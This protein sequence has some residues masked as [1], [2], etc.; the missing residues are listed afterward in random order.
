M[1][2]ACTSETVGSYEATFHFPMT[3]WRRLIRVYVHMMPVAL[4]LLQQAIQARP[5]K[6]NTAMG[7]YS[8]SNAYLNSA[9]I[10]QLHL[11]AMNSLLAAGQ[12][13]HLFMSQL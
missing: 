6:I 2:G 12:T 5:M 10:G 9:V 8:R 7:Y 1:D 4:P 3:D 11:L 13:A